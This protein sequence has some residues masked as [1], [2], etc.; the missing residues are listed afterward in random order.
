M[1]ASGV[2]APWTTSC[3]RLFDAVAALAGVRLFAAHEGQAAMELEAAAHEHG[4]A[5]G[6]IYPLPV[7]ELE[8]DAAADGAGGPVSFPRHASRTLVLDARPAVRA[9]AAD[10]AAGRSPAEIGA[11]FHDALAAATIEACARVARARG[12]DTVVLG[13]GVWQNRRLVEAVA[14]GL[15]R[16]GFRVWLPGKLPPNDGGIGWGQLAVAAARQSAG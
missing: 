11:R 1:A 16:E 13:G 6:A 4:T 9:A 15:A 2:A 3:G 10:G 7:L 8:L 5:N 12:I 14:S